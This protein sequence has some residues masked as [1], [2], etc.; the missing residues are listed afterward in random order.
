M[1][2]REKFSNLMERIGRLYVWIIAVAV[3]GTLIYRAFKY[4][5]EVQRGRDKYY[6]EVYYDKR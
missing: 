6:R 3:C 2:S 5:W 4:N 1:T